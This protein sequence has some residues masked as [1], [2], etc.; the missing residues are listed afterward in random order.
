MYIPM[1]VHYCL[2]SSFGVHCCDVY[3]FLYFPLCHSY[4]NV[5]L[6]T[7]IRIDRD[8]VSKIQIEYIILF[9]GCSLEETTCFGLLF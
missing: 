4:K 3:V 5:L 2:L 8:R 6:Q 7:L 1:M 9:T